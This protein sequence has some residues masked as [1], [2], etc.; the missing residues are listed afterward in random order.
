MCILNVL[1]V[2]ESNIQKIFLLCNISYIATY[3]T[4]AP[5]TAAIITFMAEW[6]LVSDYRMSNVLFSLF[7]ADKNSTASNHQHN[8]CLH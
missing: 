3:L 4:I 5:E 6:Q 7:P 2:I 1:V 8:G